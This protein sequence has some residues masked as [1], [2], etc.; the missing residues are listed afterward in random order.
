M[1]TRDAAERFHLLD[2]PHKLLWFS[3]DSE[4]TENMFYFFYKIIFRLKIEKHDLGSAYVKFYFFYETLN[5]YYLE[6]A[7][8]IAHVIFVLHNDRRMNVCSRAVLKF[9]RQ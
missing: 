1:K 3:S 9:P 6:T 7:N 8:H 4:G 5:S 2:N